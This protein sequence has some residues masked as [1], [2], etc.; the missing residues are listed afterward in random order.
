MNEMALVEQA[1]R[2]AATVL[3]RIARLDEAIHGAEDG[4]TGLPFVVRRVVSAAVSREVAHNTGRDIAAWAAA[5]AGLTAAVRDARTIVTRPA[6]MGWPD[7]IARARLRAAAARVEGEQP[8]LER[9]AAFM[10][11]APAKVALV[12]AGFLPKEKVRQALDN[13]AAQTEALRAAVAAMPPLAQALR[14]LSDDAMP[15]DG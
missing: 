14:V 11:R 10:E 4:L 9:L 1:E 7:T 2:A 12:P 13:L 5:I 6:D 8:H 15:R 3:D